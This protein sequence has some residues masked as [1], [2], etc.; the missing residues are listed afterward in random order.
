M[1]GGYGGWTNAGNQRISGKALVRNEN[2]A[3]A[4][5]RKGYTITG[6]HVGLQSQF[7]L[8]AADTELIKPKRKNPGRRPG[9]T[10][11]K[12]IWSRSI[13][14]YPRAM[15]LAGETLFIAGP[16]DILDFD[17]KNPAGEVSLWA[18][19][20]EDGS[21]KAQYTLRASPV[22]DSF[23]ASDGKL[24]FTTVDG[25]VICYQPAS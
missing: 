22:Y 20:T 14:F 1:A 2:R 15:L 13:P 12:Y 6:S 11:V 25:R 19:S 4:F 23:A 18:V 21:K 9:R 24:Y 17:T 7:H 5:G 16:A 10:Q 3:F 8:F